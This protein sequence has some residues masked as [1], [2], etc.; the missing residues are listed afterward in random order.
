MREDVR[1]PAF[2]LMIPAQNITHKQKTDSL[3][4]DYLFANNGKLPPLGWRPPE[5]CEY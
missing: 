1:F 4:V 5:V 3:T 2:V